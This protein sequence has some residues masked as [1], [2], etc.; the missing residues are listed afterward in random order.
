MSRVI[1]WW[2]VVLGLVVGATVLRYDI[3]N[4]YAAENRGDEFAQRIERVLVSSGFDVIGQAI[5]HR[6]RPVP[7]A[8]YF[9]DGVCDRSITVAA[10]PIT[11]LARAYAEDFQKD[12]EAVRFYY[13]DLA[14][15]DSARLALTARWF[16][17]VLAG[18]VTGR[19]GANL[20]DQVVV[21][22]PDGC[23]EPAVDWTSIWSDPRP[24]Q[25]EIE[26]DA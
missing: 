14:Y 13:R 4:A 22:W 3:R 10:F 17:G 18:A 24:R 9:Q 15:A 7:S 8:F 2:T 25:E 20:R 21:L 1:A 23:E 6:G 12:G 16:R 11:K 5:D 19:G 26:N